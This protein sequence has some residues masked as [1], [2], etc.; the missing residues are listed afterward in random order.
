MSSPP[1]I[2]RRVRSARPIIVLAA[3][4]PCV[5]AAA[6]VH[7]FTT[8]AVDDVR[9]AGGTD[10]VV[11]RS[12]VKAHLLDGSTVVYPGG[13]LVADGVVRG[14]GAR[15]AIGSVAAQ[16]TTAIALD[17]V[18]AMESFADETQVGTTV[19]VS[20]LATGAA[21]VVAAGAAVAIFGS[22]PTV[23]SDSAGQHVLEAEGFSYSIAPLFERRDVDRLRAVAPADGRLRLEVR[24]EALETHYLNHFELL[25]VRHAP[26]EYV[27]PDGDGRALVLRGLRPAARAVDR[28]GRDVAAALRDA[29]GTL[30]ATAPTTLAAATV[31]D[32]ED[33]LDVTVPAVA[34][35]DSVAVVLR[36]RNSLLNTV[37]LYDEILGAS[38]ARSLDW[39]AR[40]LSRITDAVEL[41]RWYAARMGLRVAVG[42]GAAWRPVARVGDAGPIAFH[43]VVVLV[44]A[45][46]DAAGDVRVRLSFTAD[47][48]RIDRLAV[49]AGFRR[50]TPRA[51]PVA[52]LR[53]ADG[54]ADT[55]A[56]AGVRDPDDRYLVTTPGQR[57][58]LRFDAGAIAPDSARTFLLASQGYYVEWV[59]G[60]WLKSASRGEAFRPGDASLF[61]ALHRWRN[62]QPEFEERF[63]ATKI[64]VR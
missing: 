26:G 23:Y 34:G 47:N 19:L 24:N 48:W 30:F 39:M 51:I 55:A 44:P 50:A 61:A 45:V 56:L 52:D 15:H 20:A 43:D 33:H 58:S 31:D 9:P 5:L 60:T 37:L 2:R 21:V 17:S 62:V 63:Y 13:V 35:A 57:L 28:A 36:L 41:G 22:C 25:E 11:V 59:R 64:P 38:G 53:G 27:A 1:T 14:D 18:A 4:A 3:T 12:A 54:V 46:R 7:V 16:R 40:D 29:D 8:V 49:A 42:D 32:L 6:C 10:S